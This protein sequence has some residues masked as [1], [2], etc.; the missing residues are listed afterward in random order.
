MTNGTK[1]TLGSVFAAIL[2]A[3]GQVTLLQSEIVAS[4]TQTAQEVKTLRIELMA[5]V[6]NLA[7]VNAAL[8]SKLDDHEAR[9]RSIERHTGGR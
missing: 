9:L 4:N 8:S 2:A 3:C 1:F 5:E 7:S 6:R